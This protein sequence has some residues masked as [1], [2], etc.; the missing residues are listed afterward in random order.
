L[1]TE[2]RVICRAVTELV[3]VGGLQDVCLECRLEVAAGVVIVTGRGLVPRSTGEAEET[4]IAGKAEVVLKDRTLAY[5]TVA[6]HTV[7]E[8]HVKLTQKP[9]TVTV[10]PLESTTGLQTANAV[11]ELEPGSRGEEV[12]IRTHYI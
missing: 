10:V 4:D 11:L 2:D 12:N 3:L 9:G 5:R 8:P 6:Y 1:P 7:S